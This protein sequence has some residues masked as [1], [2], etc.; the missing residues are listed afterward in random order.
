MV[1]LTE[2]LAAEQS[3][4][5]LDAEDASKREQVGRALLQALARRLNAEPVSEWSFVLDDNQIHILRSK[6]RSQRRVGT[7]TVD[8]ELRLVLGQETTE[9]ITAESC[10]RV[11]DEGVQI[12]ARF[13]TDIEERPLRTY[14]NRL[15]TAARKWWT[16]FRDFGPH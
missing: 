14:Q 3:K 10:N 4:R 13:I 15:A 6:N 9:W 5:R 16:F 8:R 7:W 2:A 11:I 12:T 1:T